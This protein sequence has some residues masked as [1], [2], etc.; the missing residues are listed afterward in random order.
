MCIKVGLKVGVYLKS[1][2]LMNYC[3]FSFLLCII[4]SDANLKFFN[5]KIIDPEITKFDLNQLKTLVAEFTSTK[6]FDTRYEIWKTVLK[7][8]KSK[9]EMTYIAKLFELSLKVG[10]GQRII[11]LSLL[12]A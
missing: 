1:I 12:D 7:T 3:Y 10:V 11:E 5:L 9:K 6:D 4:L 8:C 2:I